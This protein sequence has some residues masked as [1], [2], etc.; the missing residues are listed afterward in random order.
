M[1]EKH[2][3]VRNERSYAVFHSHNKPVR[4]ISGGFWVGGA[5]GASIQ[6]VDMDTEQ[7]ALGHHLE[8]GGGPVDVS[9]WFPPEGKSCG[10]CGWHSGFDGHGN[11]CNREK[12]VELDIGDNPEWKPRKQGVTGKHY[13]VILIDELAPAIPPGEEGGRT[14]LQTWEYEVWQKEKTVEGKADRPRK[15]LVK[16]DAQWDLSHDSVRERVIWTHKNEIDKAGLL[17]D[18]VDVIFHPFSR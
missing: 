4:G 1:S 3:L 8:P 15:R 17:P 5:E 6:A 12:C 9:A 16:K 14:M 11:P 13:D 7:R 18:E 2:W 10:N